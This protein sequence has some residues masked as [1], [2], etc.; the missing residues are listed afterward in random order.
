MTPVTVAAPLELPCGTTVK[1]RLVKAAMSEGLATPS[2]GPSDQ[3]IDLY[4]RWAEGGAGV[5]VT[6]AVM[7]DPEHLGEPN[8]VV[9]A[10][11]RHLDALRE[12]A[13]A[14]TANDTQLWMQLNHPGKQSP[15]SVN[16]YPVAPSVVPME[17]PA[18]RFFATP[19]ELTVDDIKLIVWR[20]GYAARIAQSTGFTGVQIHAA[21][22]YLINQFLSPNDNKRT[23][24]YGGDLESRMRLLVEIYEAIRD[25]VGAEFPISVKLNSSDGVSGGFDEDESLVVAEKLSELGVDVIEVSGGTYTAPLMQGEKVDASGDT[26]EIYFGDYAKQLRDKVS[27]PVLLTGGF[28]CAADIERGLDG[29]ADLIGM[30]RPLVMVPEYPNELIKQGSRKLVRLPRLSTG[31]KKLDEPLEHLLGTNWYEMQMD[32]ITDG[33]AIGGDG[34]A[35]L[36]FTLKNHGLTGLLSSRR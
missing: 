21:H 33:R 16:K 35:T 20:F 3:H 34:L 15:R 18:E 1:N 13:E 24:E 6:G 14:G 32:R 10:D 9:V 4:R 25:E 31:S 23:D 30:A 22:G 2:G 19:R 12:W 7:V 17:G 29:L 8:T 5:L 11:D 27:T 26:G 36:W 28:R